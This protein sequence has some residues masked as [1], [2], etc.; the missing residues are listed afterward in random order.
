MFRLFR[1]KPAAVKLV[2]FQEAMPA[3]F[4]ALLCDGLTAYHL[5]SFADLLALQ[6]RLQ[7]AHPGVRVLASLDNLDQAEYTSGHSLSAFDLD[8]VDGH[9]LSGL[10]P[11]L[12]EE[13][14]HQGYLTTPAE[15]PIRLANL[16]G[17]ARDVP[18]TQLRGLLDW[19]GDEGG[20]AGDLVTVNRDPEAAL[21]IARERHVLFQFV[22]VDTAAKAIAAFPNGYFS[23]DLNPMQSYVLARHLEATHGLALFGVGSR[24]LGFRRA[25]AFCE[26]EALALAIEL[27]DLYANTPP[28]ADE[29][30]ARLLTGRDWLLIRYTE[31]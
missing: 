4:T 31:S 21:Q 28:T 8:A 17:Q 12:F 13:G 22:P 2:P 18:L 5:A 19:G 26:D 6:V 11:A 25:Q 24:F 9:D 20:E 7:Q 15:F 3:T 10:D 29:D 14:E 30:L 16:L 27:G 1:K 23:S